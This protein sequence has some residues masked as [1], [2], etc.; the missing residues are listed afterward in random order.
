[1]LVCH[2]KSVVGY[3]SFARFDVIK[4]LR[5]SGSVNRLLRDLRGQ[6]TDGRL[7]LLLCLPGSDQ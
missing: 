7:V 6:W 1:M 2:L 3:Y 5:G 4:S